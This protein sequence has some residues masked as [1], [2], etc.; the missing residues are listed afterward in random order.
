MSKPLDERDALLT[1]AE[2]CE[3]AEG[4]DRDID[5]WIAVLIDPDRQV[6]VDLEPGRFPRTPIYGPT[7]LIMEQVGGKEGADYLVAATYTASLDA[8]M[9]LVP[10]GWLFSITRCPGQPAEAA[11]V[12]FR[13]RDGKHWH[14]SGMVDTKR[15]KAATPELALCAAALR[16][17]AHTK[18]TPQ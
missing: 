7:R 3:K 10:E 18:D 14:G 8:A 6:I 15:V 17:I 9:T 12:E 11:L 2:R 4:P 16:A 13:E 5:G 1:L